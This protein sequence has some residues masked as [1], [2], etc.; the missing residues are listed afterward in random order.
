MRGLF[1]LSATLYVLIYAFEAP[2]R[3]GLHT[4]GMDAA[5]FLRDGL[6]AGPLLLLFVRQCM[7]GTVHPAYWVFAIVV[8]V[9]G[10]VGYFNFHSIM[11]PVYGANFLLPM[12]FGF[13]VSSSLTQPRAKLLRLF[14]LLWLV[15]LVALYLDKF[16]LTFPWS[17]MQTTIGGLKVDVSRGWDITSGSDKR[18]AG[19]TRSSIEAA[20]LMPV[21]AFL[22]I[23]RAGFILRTIVLAA[24]GEAVFLTT[25]KG[26][27]AAF[28]AVAIIFWL[29]R[30]MWFAMLC[31]ACVTLT[32][33]TVMLPILSSG[34]L[35]GTGGGVFSLASFGM[36]I[37]DTW[38]DAWRWI[39]NHDIFPFATGLGGLSGAMRFFAADFYNPSDNFFI[40]LYGNFGIAALFYIGWANYQALTVPADLRTYAITALAILAY[41]VGYGAVI[42]ILE[43][44]FTTLYLG[45]SLG[46]LWRLHQQ[47]HNHKWADAFNPAWSYPIRAATPQQISV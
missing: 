1:V 36:R 35:M 38:P 5:I 23:R 34:L 46:T 42:G 29:P 25:Q 47:A 3:Y 9:H 22:I 43:D 7:R 27:L 28:A 18:V 31:T 17:G 32:L 30:R 11:A 20:S 26:A 10:S 6:L 15:S 39:A 44:P 41:D 4:M 13:I 21:L 37:T 19:F 8:G 40:F 33:F 24:T 16:V 2:V 45:A 12:L 14:A